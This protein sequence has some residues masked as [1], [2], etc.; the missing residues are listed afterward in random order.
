MSALL[1]IGACTE[2]GESPATS[3]N[4]AAGATTSPASEPA[5]TSASPTP[6]PSIEQRTVTKTRKVPFKTRRVNDPTLAKGTTKVRQRGVAGIKTVTYKVTYTD[7]AKTDTKLVREVV[8]RKPVTR[9]IA[10]GTKRARSCDP[11]YSGCV[12]IAS[13]VDCA[14]GSGNGPA[15]VQGPV[16]VI[17]SDIYDLDRDGDG[18]ACDT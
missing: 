18:I 13:D 12:P 2:P 5:T 3:S 10:V 14:G 4:A 6:S 17:G 7:G 11:N 15:Y 1:A 16:R 9:I 8:T